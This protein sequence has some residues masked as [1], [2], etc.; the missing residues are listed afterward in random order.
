MSWADRLRRLTVGDPQRN[1]VEQLVAMH[2]RSAAQVEHLAA[3]A[4]QAP[5]AAAERELHALAAEEGT[6]SAAVAHALSERNAVTVAVPTSASNGVVARNHWGRLV[7]ILEACQAA[8]AQLLLDTPRLLELDPTLADLLRPLLRALDT[9][10]V[11][12]RA[13]IARADPQ[14]ID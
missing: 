11:A 9:E 3:A 10:I 1:V 5:T 14:A 2:R 8:R 12:L 4:A 6:L 13:M 7:A